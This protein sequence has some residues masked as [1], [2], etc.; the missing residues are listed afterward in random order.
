MFSFTRR[1]LLASA[2]ACAGVATTAGHAQDLDA[3]V[4]EAA[5]G[6]PVTWYES[7]PEEQIDQVIEAFNERYPD[8]ELNY[9]RLVGGNSLA[10]RAVQEMQGAGRTGDVLT[11]GADHIWQLA[12]RDYLERLDWSEL[13][14]PEALTPN[15]FA[16]ATAASVYV[17]LWNTTKVSDEEAPKTWEETLD[18]KWAGRIG[19]WV[20]AASFAQLAS[21]WGEDEAEAKLK[22]FIALKPF[23]FASTFPLAQ[24][25]G[26]GEVDV[27][28]GFY[29]TAQP[30]I[31]AG[32]PLKAVALDPTP[33]H[34]IYTAIS[35]DPANLAGAKLLVAW[36]ASPEGAIAY[37][38]AT[39]RGNPLLEG[40]QT[41]ELLQGKEI[42]EWAPEDSEKLGQI[43]ERFNEMLA[44]VGEAR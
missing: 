16:V 28:I 6:G 11:G 37:E 1:V 5:E 14:I 19:H 18:S 2:I 40:T 24:Q 36:L 25:V 26:A 17:V 44:E 4:A 32:A 21:A 33:M 35:K 31:Q 29:H 43:N 30:P 13:G 34:T 8:V 41:Y 39:S 27:A 22:E 12:G 3:L 15:D 10:S 38:N 9:V 23:L 7:S 42:V 20:R